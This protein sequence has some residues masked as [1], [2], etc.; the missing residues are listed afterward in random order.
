M[1]DYRNLIS[2]GVFVFDIIVCLNTAFFEE[3]MIQENR[4]TII[5]RYLR[6]NLQIFWQEGRFCLLLSNFT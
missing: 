6:S 5:V 3:G 1:T 4:K 2:C